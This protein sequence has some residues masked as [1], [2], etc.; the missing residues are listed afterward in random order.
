[1]Y[2][3]PVTIKTEGRRCTLQP[4]EVECYPIQ[5]AT[6]KEIMKQPK[7]K[8]LGELDK[9]STCRNNKIAKKLCIRE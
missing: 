6:Y 9:K 4:K 8:M 2:P 1:M 5:A 7:V 3:L